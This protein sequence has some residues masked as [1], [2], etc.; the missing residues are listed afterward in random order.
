MISLRF[1]AA[2]SLLLL[3]SACAGEEP[4]PA[5]SADAARLT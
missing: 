2:A 3:V 5:A 4:K 1:G